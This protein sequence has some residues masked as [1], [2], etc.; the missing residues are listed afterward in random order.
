MRF[1]QY[2]VA[3]A[4][5]MALCLLLIQSTL[6]A[7]RPVGGD[8]SSGGSSTSG[9]CESIV[10]S[11]RIEES[12]CK[13][14]GSIS[15]RVYGGSGEF[16][17]RVIG[18]V[19][20]PFT[21]S[22]FI[23]GL[24]PGEYEVIVE[25]ILFNCSRGLRRV[26][27]PGDYE[28]PRL[29]LNTQ[30]VTCKNVNNGSISVASQTGGRFP[31]R[32]T[33]VS[34]P[35]A[36]FVGL[37]NA[38]GTFTGLAPGDYS[39]QMEDSCS[40]LQTRR[41]TILPYDWW[42]RDSG[43]TLTAC[44]EAGLFIH[45]RDNKER[46]DPDPVFSSFRYGW[47]RAA[48]DTAWHTT[49]S[50]TA[51][52]GTRRS[53]T[54]VVRDGCG[55]IITAPWAV[56][57]KPAL[58]ATVQT[59]L[60]GCNSFT[61]AVS[62]GTNLTDPSYCLVN[63][64][65]LQ[66]ECN[67]TGSF[68]GIPG[69]SYT[70]RVTDR[71]Y[72]TTINIPFTVVQP[73]PAITGNISV[74]RASCT[75]FNAQVNGLVNFTDPRFC[76][77]QGNSEIVC[78]TTG[79]FN[80]LTNGSYTVR[81]TDGCYDTTVVRNLQVLPL[82]PSVAA[83][84][85]MTNY[86]CSTFNAAITGQTNLNNPVYTLSQGS[87]V[88]ASNTTGVFANI[89][90]GNYSI[91][92]VND[93]AC[94]DTTIVRNFTGRKIPPRVDNDLAVVR[95]C[96]SIDL[97]VR[98][99]QQIY[100]ALYCIYD[101]NDNQIACN[102]S[103]TFRDLPYGEYCITIKN[104]PLCYD[105]TITRCI[106][107]EK[108]KPELGSVSISQS[109]CLGFSA[110]ITGARNL[111]DPVYTLKDNAGTIIAT[112]TTGIFTGIPYGSY[113]MEMQN[114]PLCYDTLITRCFSASRPKPSGGVVTA[115]NLTCPGFTATVTGLVNFNSPT[116][117]LR[118]SNG[119]V[120][121]SNSTGVFNIA[122]YENWCIDIVNDPLC[123]DTTITR[124]I[125]PVRPVPSVGAVVTD[126]RTCS[127]FRARLTGQTLL[128]NPVFNI[129][130]GSNKIVATNTT[131]TFSNVPYGSYTMQVVDGCHPEPFLVAF[132][133]IQQALDVAMEASGACLPGHTR[134]NVRIRSGYTP[135]IVTV[136]DPLNN[137][138]ATRSTS[139][140]LVTIDNLPPLGSGLQYRVDVIDACG[141]SLSQRVTPVLSTIQR[142]FTVV[143]Q[144]PTGL[145]PDGSSD[146]DV[147]VSSS[148]GAVYPVIVNINGQSANLGY[149]LQSGTT[150]TWKTVGPGTYIV[151]YDLPGGCTNKIY[152]TIVVNPYR[153]P[154]LA[155][156]SVYQCSN[157]SFSVGTQMVG[158]TAPYMYQIIGSNPS[159]PSINTGW[160]PSPVFSISNGQNYTMVRLRAVDACG[161]ASL[162]DAQVLPLQNLVVS[163]TS[164]CL[165]TAVTLSANSVA[166]AEYT[167]YRRTGSD[168]V[169]VGTGL[170]YHIPFVTPADTG[171]YVVRM[172]VNGGCLT[173]VASYHLAGDCV[174]L[175]ATRLELSGR[176]NGKVGDLKWEAAGEKNLMEYIV[177][178]SNGAGGYE[179]IGRVPAKA[180]AS[181]N[182]YSFT[183]N[184]PFIGINY[185]RVKA[186]DRDNKFSYSNTVN[187]RWATTSL[188]IYPV[189][190]RDVVNLVISNSQSRDM[191]FQL[192]NMSGQV[193]QERVLPRVQQATIPI[194]RNQL[195]SGLYLVRLTDILSGQSQTE[196]IIFE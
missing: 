187:L 67:T 54:L 106:I 83:N 192:F 2:P 98:G 85:N 84:V 184:S 182:R 122:G 118:N 25:D 148:I 137:V 28:E 64:S 191:K 128:T 115:S 65:N 37:N 186:V 56:N 36:S 111:N 89:P 1:I 193:L 144:C 79:I 21:S 114:N 147:Q 103:G 66:I 100:N 55:N 174:L 121:Q 156:S 49:N 117:R 73:V 132:S 95:K 105:T 74:A 112:N 153:F 131:G 92:I 23:T 69:G 81:V 162:S 139:D 94:Y 62:G 141:R 150:F 166:N 124:C 164:S 110:S 27:V 126:N 34:A 181:V 195:A 17:Y 163:S 58:S 38:T 169:Q 127:G 177:E 189:P 52:I 102:S 172:S 175:P 91:S 41:A 8:G 173:R 143:A 50:F 140:S 145:L 101:R 61:A 154:T 133:V 7:Q 120:V 53:L 77:Y 86:Q 68:T 159:T 116:F 18:P 48:G 4:V 157:N 93:P 130:D 178:R 168:S 33:I 12:R 88:L 123:Y 60:A 20:T 16:N 71:C 70:I 46:Q 113:C 51:S 47:V 80:G 171:T 87:A 152:D 134:M 97:T 119:E 6:F 158:G 78:N 161:N 138:A 185:Y 82:I 44:G 108:L 155:N 196:K 43:G 11:V 183:D 160:Q 188:V 19:T 104:D 107:V 146:I 14:T 22:N 31:F 63:S 179:A 30:D 39:V 96:N 129:L 136:Y 135:Y 190:A 29:T 57:P 167:W 10:L 13:A 142:S 24:S 165:F 72:D 180:A 5:S 26:I 32:Y 59:A 99:Q 45:V 90:Y 125:N 3:R 9:T 40:G 170:S 75:T 194:Y 109:E 35:D 176:R 76:V 149:S 15:V 42:I 151:R